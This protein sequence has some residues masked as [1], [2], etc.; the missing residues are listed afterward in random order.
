[1]QAN[2][3]LHMK[4]KQDDAGHSGM[5]PRLK[6]LDPRVDKLDPKNHKYKKHNEKL[7]ELDEASRRQQVEELEE[8]EAEE[9]EQAKKNKDFFMIF[10]K[11]GGVHLRALAKAS[12]IGVSIFLLLAESADRANAVVASGR[13]IA[14]ALGVSESSVSRSIGHLIKLRLI[15]KLSSGNSNVF[16][17][18]PE[19]VW[20]AW[21]TGK[22]HCMFGNA[23]VLLSKGEQ[24]LTTQ[25]RIN[26]LL[27]KTK[28][29]KE[30]I[31]EDGVITFAQDAM[32]AALEAAGQQRLEV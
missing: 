31:D 21:A 18:N 16:I 30:V 10:K 5:S 20:S 25:K 14:S 32:Q 27:A 3:R 1:M 17:L 22:N 7:Q 4:Q 13:A 12:P 11:A 6:A 24:D 8:K 19:V 9:R 29:P 2:K 15:E 28:K 23:T 26:V